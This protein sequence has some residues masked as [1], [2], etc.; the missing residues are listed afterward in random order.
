MNVLLC[1]T[2]AG[3]IRNIAPLLPVLA[4]RAISS[5]LLTSERMVHL[6]G[7]SI[8]HAKDVL[9]TEGIDTDGLRLLLDTK[10]PLSVITGTTRFMS[11]DRL[12]N[13]LAKKAG[14][15]SISVLDEWFNYRLRFERSETGELAYLP[16]AVAAQ[17]EMAK[18]EAA[19]EGIPSAVCHITGSPSLADVARRAAWFRD[20]K[21]P[22]PPFLSLKDD[23]LV[24]TFLSE[25]HAEDYGNAP[26]E[27]GKLGPFIG[28]TEHSV[29]NDIIQLLKKIGRNIIFVEKMHP[30]A[31]DEA[32]KSDS[33][34]K[35]DW[36]RVSKCDLPTLLWHSDLVI[37]MRSMALLEACILGCHAVSFQPGLIG[38]DKC[39]AV[40]LGLIPGLDSRESLKSWLFDKLAE[41]SENNA[42]IKHE[43]NY[44]FA[45]LNAAELV[46]DLAVNR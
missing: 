43:R 8:R 31:K 10:R 44:P 40:R 22:R 30:S 36:R 21:P 1:A 6:F 19:R 3:G 32:L 13:L 41:V 5:T 46:V 28:Y 33:P 38:E 27:S 15:K 35:I 25:T 16:D 7:E 45:R 29:R 14:I 9:W 2:D 20:H 4:H 39:T 12:L 37:G 18:D 24:I 34:S 23:R 17:D 26:H 42:R 11:P